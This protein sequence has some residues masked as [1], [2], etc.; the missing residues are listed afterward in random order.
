MKM[1]G[2]VRTSKW[3]QLPSQ[4]IQALC[5]PDPSNGMVVLGVRFSMFRL[6]LGL[7]LI[8]VT[9]RRIQHPPTVSIAQRNIDVLAS[10]DIAWLST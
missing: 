3:A 8:N 2:T 1:Q 6:D 4:F 10:G 5:G 7:K 9:S